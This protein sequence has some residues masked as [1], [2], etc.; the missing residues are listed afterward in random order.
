MRASTTVI[1]ASIC[2]AVLVGCG[3][4]GSTALGIDSNPRIRLVNSL[5]TPATT[6]LKVDDQTIKSDASNQFVSDYNIFT[7][8]NHDIQF[9]DGTT[10]AS[11]VTSSQLLELNHFYTAV[12]YRNAS[13]TP[14][15]LL[16]SDKPAASLTNGQIRVVNASTAAVD[17]YVTAVDADISGASP[18]I[19]SETP[20]DATAA[21]TEANLGG[22]ST[23]TFEVRITLPGSKAVIAS[24]NVTLNSHDAKTVLVTSKGGSQTLTPL[25]TVSY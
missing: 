14:S 16:L 23:G 11:L 4:A 18:T 7:N 24:S 8:G 20:G 9:L 12:A 17:V 22:S 6:T 25:P 15:L 10:S 13:D 3:G 5:G 21:Y 2:A 19:S 1:W